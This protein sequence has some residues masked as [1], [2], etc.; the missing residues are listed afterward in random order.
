MFSRDL[1]WKVVTAGCGIDREKGNFVNY[2]LRY[3]PIRDVDGAVNGGIDGGMDGNRIGGGIGGSGI[4]GGIDDS[5]IDGGIDDSGIGGGIDDSGRRN[6]SGI[7]SFDLPIVS[8]TGDD[9]NLFQPRFGCAVGF[10][11]LAVSRLSKLFC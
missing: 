6:R 2:L 7:D 1:P 10:V 8:S 9:T 3:R 5:G 4:D 11:Y